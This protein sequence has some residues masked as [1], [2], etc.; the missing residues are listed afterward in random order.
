M[1]IAIIIA[2]FEIV[3]HRA[4]RHRQARP[5]RGGGDGYVFQ[6]PG[7]FE[8]AARRPSLTAKKHTWYVSYEFARRFGEATRRCTQEDVLSK[9]KLTRKRVQGADEST[10]AT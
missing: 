4:L 7:I 3:A 9:P 8:P 6:M 2:S 10:R 1:I 5:A